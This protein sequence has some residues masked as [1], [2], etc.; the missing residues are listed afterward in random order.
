MVTTAMAHG[1]ASVCHIGPNALYLCLSCDR[2]DL[3]TLAIEICLA[4]RVDSV[5]YRIYMR[6]SSWRASLPGS[7]HIWRAMLAPGLVN[8]SEFQSLVVVLRSRGH[9]V[10]DPHVRRVLSLSGRADRLQAAQRVAQL[11]NADATES[12]VSSRGATK[13]IRVMSN[14]LLLTKNLISA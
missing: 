10:H 1:R 7:L 4:L 3:D 13:R 5:L 11:G 9:I 14:R 6:R 8:V 12:T 2:L